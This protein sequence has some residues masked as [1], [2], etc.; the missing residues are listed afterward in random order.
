MNRIIV[1][2]GAAAV[3]VGACAAS[4]V[5][6]SRQPAVGSPSSQIASP[7]ASAP[8][9]P[10]SNLAAL[11]EE[12]WGDWLADV[13]SIPDLAPIGPRIQLSM[14]WQDGL[15]VW[16][17]T[18]QGSQVFR[19]GSATPAAGEIRLITTEGSRGCRVG[20]D[21]RYRAKRSTD[22]MFLTV[23]PIVDACVARATMFG[24]TW[25]R[26]L[27]AVNDGRHGI[28]NYFS[29][30]IEITL[31]SARFAAGGAP[32]AADINSESGF[33]LTAVKNPSGYTKPCA[34]AGGSRSPIDPTAAAFVAYARHLP[35]FTV[36]TNDLTID[37]HRAT[38]LS[39]TTKA[40]VDCPNDEVFEFGPNDV[41]V[42]D[43][44]YWSLKSG[45]P[46]SIWLV[47]VGKDLYLLQ[48]RGP[49]VSDTIA[50]RVLSTIHFVDKLPAP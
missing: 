49:D 22:G 50:E 5:Q 36:K 47:D 9:S 32:E 3:L 48:Y 2:I 43:G 14:D 19:S 10:S 6:P 16:V 28:V 24:R 35:G 40:S 21:G 37:G 38:H 17:Q 42:T 18:N 1:A 45:D 29:P 33:S 31:P 4:S 20:D 13:G 7:V 30:A 27:G 23:T 12:V 11:P 15:H 26:S 25:V 34:T 8:P 41:N 46:D 39:I 44:G